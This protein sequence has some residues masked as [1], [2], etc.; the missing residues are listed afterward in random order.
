MHT[1]L[2]VPTLALFSSAAS[3]GLLPSAAVVAGFDFPALE[4]LDRG[5]CA[6]WVACGD[7]VC[8]G[9]GGVYTRE[10]ATA[11]KG[12]TTGASHDLLASAQASAFAFRFA[13]AAAFAAFICS[14]EPLGSL[15]RIAETMGVIF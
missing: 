5:V 14:V 13:V 12:S 8:D 2:S 11:G 4:P 3:S 6:A 9:E 10:R 15:G 1:A 7:S